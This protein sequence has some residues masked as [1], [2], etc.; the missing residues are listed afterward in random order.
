MPKRRHSASRAR[1]AAADRAHRRWTRTA[2]AA[3]ASVR[4]ADAASL[5][6]R[7]GTP[8][9]VE[10]A[11]GGLAR[12]HQA[13]LACRRSRSTAQLCRGPM[14]VSS[15]A[16]RT[17]TNVRRR[18]ASR[19]R[20]LGQHGRRWDILRGAIAL[21]NPSVHESLS[22]VLLERGHRPAGCRQR[23][24]DVTSDQVRD[25]AG[26]IAVDFARPAEA[27]EAIAAA[28]RSESDRAAMGAR[29]RPT[30]TA[31]SAG[32]GCST[33]TNASPARRGAITQ[34]PRPLAHDDRPTTGS[35]IAAR[36]IPPAAG[37]ALAPTFS[38]RSARVCTATFSCCSACRSRR[39]GGRSRG[40]R[41]DRRTARRSGPPSD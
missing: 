38:W 7:H 1:T 5:R 25:S 39:R 24:C 40:E 33:S 9:Q 22:L 19:P 26:G 12:A 32:T 3:L 23:Q 27:A 18:S 8:G 30:S 17:D 34:R 21:I 2:D 41:C 29:G 16:R 11:A 37:A 14:C 4:S 6:G 10:A 35:P 20:G 31:R 15:I 13:T 28:L 36:T